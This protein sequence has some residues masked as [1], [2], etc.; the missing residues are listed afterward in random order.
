MHEIHV[1]HKILK[2]M[3]LVTK[4]CPLY[5][6]TFFRNKS[7]S[8][9]ELVYVSHFDYLNIGLSQ[10]IPLVLVLWRIEI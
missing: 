6:F 5:V 7:N 2:F 9:T 3:L 1:V 8:S 4:Y 10:L